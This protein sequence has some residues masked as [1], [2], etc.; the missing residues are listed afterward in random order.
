MR[1]TKMTAVIRARMHAHD[2]EI[3]ER[4]CKEQ[5][6]NPAEVLRRLV[7][8]FNANMIVLGVNNSDSDN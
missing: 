5:A 1:E 3:F 7:K 6:Q 8:A 2:I 4:K